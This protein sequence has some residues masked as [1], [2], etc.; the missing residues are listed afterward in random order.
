MGKMQ[1]GYVFEDEHNRWFCRF[2]YQDESGKRRTI[3]RR[4]ENKTEAKKLLDRLLKDYEKRG[5]DGLDGDRMSFND[6]AEFYESTYLHPPQYVDGRKVTGQRDHYN[7]KCLLRILRQH[8]GT[9]KIKTISHGQIERYRIVRLQTPTKHGKQRTIAAVNRE[10]SILRKVFNVAKRNRWVIE[11]PFH[12]G[13]PL[14]R[15]GDE[16]PRERILTREEEAR[17]LDACTGQR[18]YLRPVI[19]CAIDTGMRRGE[20]LKMRWQDVDLRNRMIQVQALNTKTLRERKVYMTERLAYELQWLYDQSE[21]N[22]TILVFGIEGSIKKAFGT[23][24]RLAGLSDVH[25]HDLR[26][27]AASRLAASN[28]PIAEIAR[29]LGH[30]QLATSYR[31]INA[32]TDSLK[33]AAAALDIFNARTVEKESERPAIH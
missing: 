21:K 4:A 5:R 6:L 24:R 11:N 30:T 13:D 19:I 31:Y 27:T 3:R 7:S 33:R 2:D 9:C 17:L 14:I 8:F 22:D 25:F 12:C 29:V 28:I 1:T 15:P 18:T 26:H 32:N 20:I 10:L 16:R 23:A